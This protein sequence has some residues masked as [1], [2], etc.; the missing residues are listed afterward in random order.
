MDGVAA[1]EAEPEVNGRRR[2]ELAPRRVAQADE[3][4]LPPRLLLNELMLLNQVAGQ[5]DREQQQDTVCGL[6]LDPDGDAPAIEEDGLHYS[7]CSEDCRRA[8]VTRR[9][10]HVTRNP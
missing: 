5:D 1:L 6:V 4:F 7:F 3:H 9:L 2:H 10:G 8:F